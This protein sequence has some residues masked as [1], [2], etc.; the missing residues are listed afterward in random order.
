MASCTKK[1]PNQ[2]VQLISFSYGKMANSHF[3]SM[4]ISLSYVFFSLYWTSNEAHW[5][6][7]MAFEQNDCFRE[8]GLSLKLCVLNECK[9]CEKTIL[10][11]GTSITNHLNSQLTINILI[12]L[13]C[14]TNSNDFRWF[15]CC[16][17]FLLALFIVIVKQSDKYHVGAN[18]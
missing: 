4:F 9:I 6:N 1:T 15:F 12:L 3:H 13:Q 11:R 14:E 16:Y 8:L 5:V 10:Q 17:C 7:L 18:V 2:Y